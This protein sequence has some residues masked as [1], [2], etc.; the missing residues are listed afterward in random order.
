M[1]K[2]F[3]FNEKNLNSGGDFKK[4]Q[5]SIS[6]LKKIPKYTTVYQ[7]KYFILTGDSGGLSKKKLNWKVRAG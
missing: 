5:I 7:Q 2:D 4:T 6:F 3:G 1:T